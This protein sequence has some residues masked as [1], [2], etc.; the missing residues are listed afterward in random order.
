M[1]PGSA[2]TIREVVTSVSS[3][4][5]HCAVLS[6]VL[7]AS[8]LHVEPLAG[9]PPVPE[10]LLIKHLLD[11]SF[12]GPAV[13]SQGP[14]PP[15]GEAEAKSSVA[16]QKAAPAEETPDLVQPLETPQ[17]IPQPESGI[18]QSGSSNGPGS[19]FPIGS[20]F[21]V[22]GSNGTGGWGPGNGPTGVLIGL[23]APDEPRIL[24]SEVSP[25][26][27]VFYVQPVYPEA[28]RTARA[29]GT[30]IL[31][32]VVGRTGAVEEV[33]VLKSSPLFDTAAVVAVKRWKYEP[34]LFGGSKPVRVFMTV[35]VEFRLK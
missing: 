12:Q 14:P 34:A 17:E 28:A 30:V 2:R 15:K 27:R 23:P 22:E 25:P 9:P 8:L 21:G 3:I 20:P 6:A 18:D 11:V 33:K 29:E 7:V 10:P 1:T 35:R 16:H 26:K 19:G 31:E 5:V 24:S 32:V 13:P 4:A